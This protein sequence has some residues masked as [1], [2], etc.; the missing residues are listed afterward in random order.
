MIGLLTIVSMLYIIF[1]LIIIDKIKP[2]KDLLFFKQFILLCLMYLIL[3]PIILIVVSN[4]YFYIRNNKEWFDWLK[5]PEYYDDVFSIVAIYPSIFLI[6]E[7]SIFCGYYTKL[8][9]INGIL[10]IIIF[11]ITA[12]VIFVLS[13]ILIRK[14]FMK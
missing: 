13:Q 12:S 6:F 2:L 10:L 9:E 11:G 3:L 1:S 14:I 5:I 8:P 7:F 4:V